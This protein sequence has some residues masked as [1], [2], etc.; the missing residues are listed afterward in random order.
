MTKVQRSL[1]GIA[2]IGQIAVSV[3]VGTG[4]A[5]GAAARALGAVQGVLLILASLTFGWRWY[6]DNRAQQGPTTRPS[7]SDAPLTGLASTILEAESQPAR[8]D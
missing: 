7:A 5:T 3:A 1:I 6:S 4:A 2:L 8:R